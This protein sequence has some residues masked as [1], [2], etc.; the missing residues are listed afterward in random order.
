[1]IG[2]QITEAPIRVFVLPTQYPQIG[3][4]LSEKLLEGGVPVEQIFT[5]TVQ[6]FQSVKN[7]FHDIYKSGC[8]STN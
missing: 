3:F 1:M 4:L 7:V 5:L 2:R 8:I 6:T